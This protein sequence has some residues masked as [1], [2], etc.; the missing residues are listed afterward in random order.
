MEQVQKSEKYDI[1]VKSAENELVGKG[2]GATMN[3]VFGIIV[4]ASN[5]DLPIDLAKQEVFNL[6]AE[7]VQD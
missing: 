6:P 7:A 4:P 5:L 3:D 1:A 2:K